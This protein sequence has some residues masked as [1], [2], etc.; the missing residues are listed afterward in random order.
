MCFRSCGIRRPHTK[1]VRSHS[2]AGNREK[3]SQSLVYSVLSYFFPCFLHLTFAY[4]GNDISGSS[5]PDAAA[6]ASK[7]PL[8]GLAPSWTPSFRCPSITC[9]RDRNEPLPC[10]PRLLP[11]HRPP[12]YHHGQARA[13]RT[14]GWRH[15]EGVLRASSSGVGVRVRPAS[16][17]ANLAAK[18]VASIQRGR[19]RQWLASQLLL[20][21]QLRTRPLHRASWTLISTTFS[22]IRPRCVH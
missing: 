16:S 1:R 5:F 12:H 9:S 13:H 3:S 17:G 4:G 14:A 10:R 22:K 20:L 6:A 21:H 7:P 18:S 8:A 11:L 2:F 15:R 19:R